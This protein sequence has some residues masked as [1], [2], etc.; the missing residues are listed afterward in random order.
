[1]KKIVSAIFILCSVSLFS[2]IIEDR[3]KS[4]MEVYYTKITELDT[5]RIGTYVQESPMTLRIGPTS[6]MFFGT[7]RFW[8]DSLRYYDFN[9]H[10][11]LNTLR[12][13]SG[14]PNWW[15]PLGGEEWEYIYK[16]IPSGKITGAMLYDGETRYYEEDYEKPNW[17]ILDS[18]KTISGIECIL[19]STNYR[20]REW[21]AWFAPDIAVQEG[22][23]KLTGLPGLILEAYDTKKHYKFLFSGVKYSKVLNVGRYIFSHSPV[24]MSRDDYLQRR[25][26]YITRPLEDLLHQRQAQALATGGKIPRSISDLNIDTTK[27]ERRDFEETNYPH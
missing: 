16:N 20:G 23:W 25:Y 11:Q 22:P 8:S 9:T 24:K 27:Q 10:M 2:E 15:R 1:M 6:S 13:E 7:K 5:N 12:R 3:E 21:N 14:D 17:V 19:A 4:V 18:V 26:R